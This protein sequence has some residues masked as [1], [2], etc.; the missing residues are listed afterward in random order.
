MVWEL[1]LCQLHYI[2]PEESKHGTFVGRIA[3]DLGLD[4]GEINPRMLRIISRDEKEYFQVNLQNGILFVNNIIDRE[5]LCPKIAVCI[6]SLQVIVDKPVEM[7]RVDVEIEDI[8]DNYP[9]FAVNELNLIIAEWRPP[10]SSFPL[11]GAF[12]ADV[13]TNSIKTYE[14]SSNEYFSLDIQ[15]DKHQSKS[16]ELV[17]RKSLDREQTPRYNLTLTAF[18]GGKPRLSGK[19]HLFIAVQDFNDNAPSFKQP[20]YEISL[21]ENS[22]VGTL[23]IRLNATDLDQG[24]NS[25][26]IY[27][28]S[29]LVPPQVLS[30]FSI[31]HHTGDIQ[32]KGKLDYETNNLYEIKI[33]AVDN[34]HSPLIGHCKLLVSVLDVNDN[35]PELTVTSLSVPVPEDSPQGTVVAIISVNDRDSGKNSKVNCYISQRIPFKIKPTFL[36]YYSLTVD[37]PLDREVTSQYE[38]V[39]T[40]KDEGIPFLSIT[41]TI[42]VDISDVNDNAPSFQQHVQTIFI[43]ENNQP[44]SHIYTVSA[45]DSDMNQ[46]SFI[47]YSLIESAIDDIPI[48]SYISVN[49]ENGNIFPLMS[50]DH[51]HIAFFQC[52]I[53]AKDAGLPPLSSNMTLNVFVE[54]INDNAPA[55]S[56]HSSSR[57]S[58]GNVLVPKSA[59]TGYLVTKVKAIDA[60]SG[61]NAWISYDFK[62]LAENT[63]FGIGHHTG[64][65]TIV[66]P[67]ID[68]DTD[69]YRLVILAKDHGDPEISDTMTL[70]ILLVETQPDVLLEN[71]QQERKH[72]VF[73]EPNIYLIIS[74]CS[75][76][77]LFLIILIVYMILKRVRYMEEV[78]ELSKNNIFPSA[79]GSWTYSQQR[80]YNSW[81]KAIPSN[82]DL[83]VFTPYGHQSSE[84]E[85]NTHQLQFAANP[86][87]KVRYLLC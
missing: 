21:L 15:I 73:S 43:K 50:F 45:S 2:I 22:A 13:G 16:I 83:I 74:I 86:S 35:P 82:N 55:F 5:E 69:E 27:N 19:T 62:D 20:V 79:A 48:S 3:Q 24:E 23:V 34:G 78:N 42:L 56:P 61:Y 46:N 52:H 10:G 18:D 37:G 47:T 76:S 30:I 68:S 32:V 26:I 77:S 57:E 12:D 6:V 85:S 51:E 41:K 81:L 71:K 39:I 9:V 14:L 87:W 80:Q 36:E 31:N 75:I 64:E 70:T 11:E 7:Y 38:V 72:N 49:A 60:D 29:N 58:T 67:F 59:E 63:P 1:V 84:K 54:D 8:N 33:D 4:I 17:L 66:R 44:G 28:F 40:A 25:K 65:I 53:K